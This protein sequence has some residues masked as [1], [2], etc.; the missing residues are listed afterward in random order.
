LRYFPRRAPRKVDISLLLR[1]CP[2]CLGDLVHRTDLSGDYYR[3]L[4]CNARAAPGVYAEQL[5]GVRSVAEPGGRIIPAPGLL[6]P[7]ITLP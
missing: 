6:P 4:Q 2:N 1:V 7:S 5:T 3:C